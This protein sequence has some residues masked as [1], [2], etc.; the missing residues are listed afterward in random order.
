MLPSL[1]AKK[2]SPTARD[3]DRIKVNQ[4]LCSADFTDVATLAIADVFDS[5]ATV[6]YMDNATVTGPDDTCIYISDT[7]NDI[8]DDT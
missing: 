8:D 1:A 5:D 2:P 3:S 7:D 4:R 6:N